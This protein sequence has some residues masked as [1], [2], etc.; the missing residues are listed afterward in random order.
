MAKDLFWVG[1]RIRITKGR[2]DLRPVLS[3]L[4]GQPGTVTDGRK[5]REEP[6][7]SYAIKLDNFPGEFAAVQEALEPLYDG[8]QKISWSECAWKPKKEPVIL[9]SRAQDPNSWSVSED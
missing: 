8:D 6:I 9:C 1:Q 7:Q 5:I 4:L 2:V 3:E